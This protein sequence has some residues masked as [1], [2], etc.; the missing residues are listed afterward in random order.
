MGLRVY[1]VYSAF[2]LNTSQ[3]QLVAEP[4]EKRDWG[5]QKTRLF[6]SAKIQ[7]P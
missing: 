3:N 2:I 1:H 4:K 5:K 7:Q 6:L